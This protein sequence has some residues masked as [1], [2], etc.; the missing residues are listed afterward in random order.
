MMRR[1][2]NVE[3]R[4]RELERVL[5]LSSLDDERR[6]TLHFTVARMY[7][8]IGNHDTAFRHY[9]IGNDRRKTRQAYEPAEYSAFVAQII[10]S[11]SKALFDEKKGFGASCGGQSLL[12][13]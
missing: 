11:F 13:G 12:L 7:D 5:E 8:E 3:A 1:F 2:D 4:L 10:A 6:T 9:K